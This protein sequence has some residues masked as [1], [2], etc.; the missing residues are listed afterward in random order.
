MS[1]LTIRRTFVQKDNRTQRKY[2]IFFG[3]KENKLNKK[4]KTSQRDWIWRL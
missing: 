1:E 3:Y 2:K 4:K